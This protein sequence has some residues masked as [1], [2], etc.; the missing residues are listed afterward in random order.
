MDCNRD[1]QNT[2]TT[3]SSASTIQYLEEERK[4][5]TTPIASTTTESIIPTIYPSKT[6]S[7]TTATEFI[8]SISTE[9]KWISPLK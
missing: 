5:T 1:I 7:I 2:Y 8:P 9:M 6:N 3:Q 4:L